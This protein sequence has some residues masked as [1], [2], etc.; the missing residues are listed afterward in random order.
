MSKHEAE[1]SIY[2]RIADVT[3]RSEIALPSFAAFE[4]PPADAD[5]TLTLTDEKAPAGS[6]IRSGSI[7]HRK[8]ADG[9]FC[10]TVAGDDEGLFI[11]RDY[12]TL[13]Y[14]AEGRAGGWSAQR[15]VRLALECLLARRGFVSIHAAAV[16]LD[17]EAY[18]FTA[19][20]G[21]GKSTRARAWIESLGARL[22]SGDRPLI[23]VETMEL[24]GVPWDG[25]E[26]CFRNV[27]I[28]LNTICEVRRG[29]ALHGRRLSQPQ[30]RRLLMRQC[31][32][33][34]W[35]TETAVI[36][37]RN[38]LR[39]SRGAKILRVF[40]GRS[41]GD[42]KRLYKMIRKH[43]YHKEE[44]DMKAKPGFTVRRLVGEYVLMP[45]DENI[46]AFNGAVMLNSVSAFIWEKLQQEISRSELLAA[47]L[48]EFEVDEET[49]AKDLDALLAELT[50]LGLIE[51]G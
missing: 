50:R 10:H 29:K 41:S 36:Q 25:K 28:P 4:V 43:S 26:Q 22:V 20:S 23:C 3:L 32:L 15:Y 51:Q 33:P 12:A 24:F 49:A 5:V 7:L 30:S 31:F 40:G 1:S 6:E 14:R 42:A 13:R 47:V 19:P 35:D 46:A 38:I 21:V 45:I 18:L 37:M 9:W 48:A 44:P 34:M 39:L 27:R 17:G 2:Y 8:L 16:E 11:S